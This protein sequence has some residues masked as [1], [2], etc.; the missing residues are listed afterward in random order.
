[1]TSGIEWQARVGRS[2]ADNYRLTDRAF[3]GLTDRLLERIAERGANRVLD[4]GCGAGEL[5]LAI[6]RHRP[7]SEV[8]G[9]DVSPDLVSVATERSELTGNANFVLADAGSWT[10][11]DFAPDLIASR[12]GVMFF[13]E[14]AAAF[15]NL[16]DLSA[17]G[18]Q[19]VFSCFRSPSE[20]PW[21]SEAAALLGVES[22]EDPAAPGP[23][24]F[25]DPKHVSAILTD[26]G[27]RDPQFEAVNFAYI[28]GMGDD[29]VAD[30]LAFFRQ[31]GPAARALSALEGDE[32]T[33]AEGWLRDWLEE[34]RS[35]DMIAFSAAAWIVSARY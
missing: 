17:P 16:H 3:A 2:W 27:W 14:P 8:I 18:A 31:I 28:A 19:L 9:V 12:H 6:A 1:M 7:G 4:V 20:N 33:R 11:E 32:R 24:A 23:F 30:A 22:A 10:P 35:G 15:A 21:A 13:D 25:A 29:P 5:A 26:A 34:H